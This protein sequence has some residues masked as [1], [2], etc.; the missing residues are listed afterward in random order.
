M[1]FVGRAPNHHAKRP[2]SAPVAI[3]RTD[4]LQPAAVEGQQIAK[5]ASVF[6]ERVRNERQIAS[7]QRGNLFR[8][9]QPQFL[10]QNRGNQ[11]TGI[12]VDGI[13]FSIV[14]DREGGMLEKTCVVSH[15]SQ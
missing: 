1:P 2:Q 10:Q 11:S 9:T 5:A 15:T 4:I 13:S 3:L 6:V 8:R 12:I 7:C 14:W